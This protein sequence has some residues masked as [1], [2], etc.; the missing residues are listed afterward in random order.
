MGDTLGPSTPPAPAR[1]HGFRY[2]LGGQHR[3]G[4]QH[5]DLEPDR[6]HHV[7]DLLLPAAADG[8]VDRAPGDYII[9]DGWTP[10]LEVSPAET[11]AC[12][13]VFASRITC[14][15][16][17][18]YDNRYWSLWKLPMFGCT[19]AQD[20]LRE[21]MAAKRAF[22]DCYVRVCAFDADK[23]V[24]TASFLVQRISMSLPIEKRSVA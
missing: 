22:P 11:S 6:Q 16:A 2:R 7:R 9:S 24:Q 5:D 18:Y 12:D 1:H 15:T 14:S 20:V 17:C 10:C 19:N 3:A 8:R 13:D 4:A 23:Q 21:I